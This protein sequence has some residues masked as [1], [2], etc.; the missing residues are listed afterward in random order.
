MSFDRNVVKD[1]LPEIPFTEE[2]SFSKNTTIG[3]GGT[4]SIALFP[5]SAAELS[6]TV[7]FLADKKAPFCILGR[8]A[9]VLASDNGLQ[10]VVVC[11]RSVKDIKFS[12]NFVCCGCG[13]N[14]GELIVRARAESL[15]GIEFMAGIP[16]TVGGAVF[17][18]AGAQ[19]Q[20]IA[21]VIETVDVLEVGKII[22]LNAS[23]CN[24][25][26]KHSRFM[27]KDSIILGACLRLIHMDPIM[28]DARLERIREIRSSLP[29]GRSMGCVFKNPSDISAGALIEQAGLKGVSCGGAFISDVHANFI[30]NRG[31]A[32]ANDVLRLIALS[33][34]TV[35][36]RTGILLREEIRYI[37][38]F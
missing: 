28:I 24:F 33:K 8:G 16:A 12:Q 5:R 31:N 22:R 23:E 32:T 14:I 9:N 15:G 13:I 27:E 34:E 7:C 11:T 1:G 25:S 35:Y 26:Y 38:D 29:K 18:N 6:K 10:G 36:K 30:I 19:R 4:A 21:S 37:G 2:F 3:I 17:M 20:Y